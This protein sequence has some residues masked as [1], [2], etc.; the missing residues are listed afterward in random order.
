M[1]IC[2]QV[3]AMLKENKEILGALTIVRVLHFKGQLSKEE[4]EELVD[5]YGRAHGLDLS[6]DGLA[7]VME[8]TTFQAYVDRL[9][10]ADRHNHQEHQTDSPD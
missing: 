1:D 5:L 4:M 7:K 2:A 8:S 10:A 6:G 9:E 3:D